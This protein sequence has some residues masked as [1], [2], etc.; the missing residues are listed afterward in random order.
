[1][2]TLEIHNQEDYDA[3]KDF[4]GILIIKAGLVE[5]LGNATVWASGNATVWA[6]GNATVRA[7]DNATVGALGNATV[8]ALGNAT[9][10]ASGNATVEALGNATVE[11]SDNA[12]V[13]AW[14]DATARASGNATVWASG[15]ATVWAWDSA[16]VE[17]LGNATVRASDN[18]T[19][20][21]SDNA[22]VR[23]SG[24]A[25]V[26][27]WDNASILTLDHNQVRCLMNATSKEYIEPKYNHE[28][29]EAIADHDGT[30]LVLYKSVNPK[31]GCDFKTGKIQYKIGTV[32]ECP[33][34]DPDPGRECGGGLYLSLSAQRTQNFNVGKIGEILKCLV[35]PE[36]VIIYESN[37]DKVRCRAVRPICV[38]DAHGR[39]IEA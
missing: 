26:R 21:A 22:T 38:V 8:R 2:K 15:N 35:R 30:D 32:V 39:P 11:A 36:D 29:L 3:N 20:R 17:A 13:W 12:T 33:D 7:W 18:A 5:V 10:R 9:V 25:T 24:N 16:T 14:D 19:V 31:T 28:L 27:A 1:M 23:A 6:S 37:I 34:W 4:D